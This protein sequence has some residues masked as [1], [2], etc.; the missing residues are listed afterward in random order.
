MTLILEHHEERSDTLAICAQVSSDWESIATRLLWRFPRVQNWLNLCRI[1]APLDT[2]RNKRLVSL[3]LI[4][5]HALFSPFFFEI[6]T[7]RYPRTSYLADGLALNDMH[8]L[9]A[10]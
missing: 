1:L 9:F 5:L 7:Y 4:F 6:F 8:V 3:N 2:P 10:A